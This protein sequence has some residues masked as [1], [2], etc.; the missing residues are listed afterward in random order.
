MERAEQPDEVGLVTVSR[1]YL[2][3]ERP[4]QQVPAGGFEA[5]DLPRGNGWTLWGWDLLENEAAPEGDR[6]LQAQ[7]GKKIRLVFDGFPLD[8]QNPI[9][10][11]LWM[12]TDADD[13]RA[14][15]SAETDLVRF[16]RHTNLL[17][18]NTNGQWRRVGFYLRPAAG[19]TSGRFMLNLPEPGALAVDDLRICPVSEA[20]FSR[21][22]QGWRNQYPARDLSPRP[23]DGRHLALFVRK[24]LTEPFDDDALLVMGIGSSY[25]NM[26]G[27]GERLIQHLRDLGTTRPVIYQKH[28]GSAVNYDYT[29][30]WMLQ[31][32]VERQPDLVILYSGGEAADLD[33]MLRGFRSRSTADIIVASL[34]LRERDE[35]ISPETIDPPQWD[36]IREVCRDHG[37]EF[38][39]NRREWAIYLQKLGKPIPYLLKDAVHQNDHGALVINENIV[40]HITKH[41]DPSYGPDGR[42]RVLRPGEASSVREGESVTKSEGEIR[43]RFRGNRVDLL[44]DVQSPG[45]AFDVLIDGMPA[46]DFPAFPR[47]LIVP[48]PDN[49]RPERGMT[50]DRAP[51]LVRLGEDI[52]PQDWTIRMT[53]DQ[54]DYELI[55]SVTGPDGSGNNG[56]D[57]VSNSGQIRIPTALWRRRLN[58]DGS[59]SNRTG[60]VFTFSVQRATTPTVSFAESGPAR[61]SLVEN[62]EN[63]WHRIR[64]VPRGRGFRIFEPPRPSSE[65][66]TSS[67]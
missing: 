38:V 55:G 59:Y 11:S 39:E 24:A 50:A 58:R 7:S 43:I 51:H 17:V 8:G 64:L 62:A 40:R 27:N 36:A 9:R 61:V 32:V 15:V 65:T 45:P 3:G 25:T 34:H 16:G 48:G 18:P 31:H 52:V 4:S 46:A 44:A 66:S 42:E 47:T 41:P 53:S 35:V 57:F 60:D 23:S 1:S 22:W 28:V 6:F 63:T 10:I 5:P 56:A 37:V 29:K 2:P 21:A 19:A 26:L 54:G 12:K 67:P 20:E 33:E 14:F 30:G 13:L 49:H